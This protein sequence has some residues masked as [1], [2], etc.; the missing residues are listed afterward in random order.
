MS[1]PLGR[2]RRA[3]SLRVLLVTGAAFFAVLVGL[4]VYEE[5]RPDPAVLAA[6]QAAAVRRYADSIYPASRDAGQ[7]IVLGIR[8]DITEFREGR[9]SV[10]AWQRDMDARAEE[11]RRARAA[12]RAVK[13]PDVLR[14]AGR[15][16]DAAFDKY[17]Q[18][19]A[20][21]RSAGDVSGPEREQR[22]TQGT[23]L[24]DQGDRLFDRGAARI[25]AARR[26]LGYGPD[27]RFPDKTEQEG[28]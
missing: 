17:L 22:I 9:M 18:A 4:A 24:G 7:A 23:G 27:L 2:R 11:F 8:P 20:V 21:L 25:Q 16:F 5:R 28:S 12:F 13:V 15:W 3:P 26:A 19:V 1:V 10:A 14:D 6:R